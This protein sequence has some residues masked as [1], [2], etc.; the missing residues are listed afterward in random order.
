[1]KTRREKGGE[2][3]GPGLGEKVLPKICYLKLGKCTQQDLKCLQVI[4]IRKYLNN[5]I[6]Q[7]ILSNLVFTVD[8]LHLA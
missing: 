2:R 6:H 8:N 5:A 1:M 4:L 7:V 3:K